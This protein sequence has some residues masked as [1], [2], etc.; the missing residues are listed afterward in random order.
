MRLSELEFKRRFSVN[1]YKNLR[2]MVAEM[3]MCKDWVND[4]RGD[5]YPIM[6]KTGNVAERVFGGS[7]TVS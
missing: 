7:Y 2:L 1:L 5:P 4:K 6:H 3:S